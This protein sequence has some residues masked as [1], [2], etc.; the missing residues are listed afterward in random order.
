MALTDQ[1]FASVQPSYGGPIYLV[2]NEIYGV[3]A[4]GFK[5]HNHCTGLEV[6]HNTCCS[7]GEGFRSFNRWQNGP[8]RSQ[9]E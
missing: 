9:A 4:P 3:T 2:R 5:L 1:C 8:R 6:Y 7:A